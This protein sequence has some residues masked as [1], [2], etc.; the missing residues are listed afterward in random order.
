MAII[1]PILS[2]FD[3]RGIKKAVREF[4]KAKGAF[5]KTTV[6][7][8]YVG[9]SMTNLGQNLTRT[10]TP[11][12]IGLG[13]GIYKAVQAASTLSESISK[14][15]AVFKENATVVQKWAKTTSAAF[16]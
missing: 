1:I 16:G 10:V 8:G 3:E 5:N 6:A 12:M 14:T 2:Q 11:A 4:E 7:V 15:N 13:V 9:Q